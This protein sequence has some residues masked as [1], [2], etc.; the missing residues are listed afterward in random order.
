MILCARISFVFL[1]AIHHVYPYAPKM[2]KNR[3]CRY[4][5]IHFT[6]ESAL[7][8]KLELIA[9]SLLGARSA[10]ASLSARSSTIL[11]RFNYLHLADLVSF[12]HLA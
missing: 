10:S 3:F 11:A 8:D 6:N 7:G 4:G 12:S 1:V 5:K 9:L 2:S